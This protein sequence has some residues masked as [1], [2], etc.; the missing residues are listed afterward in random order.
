[1]FEFQYFRV[2]IIVCENKVFFIKMIKKIPIQRCP[3]IL[4]S[5]ENT[6]GSKLL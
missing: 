5:S 4:R 2:M 6:P 1:M 3:V